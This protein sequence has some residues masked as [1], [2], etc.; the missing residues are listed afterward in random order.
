VGVAVSRLCGIGIVGLGGVG[1]PQAK[2]DKIVK[3]ARPAMTQKA[4]GIEAE[5]VRS[6]M[7]LQSLL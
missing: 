2:V 5:V 1:E 4:A 6:A 7:N 3:T